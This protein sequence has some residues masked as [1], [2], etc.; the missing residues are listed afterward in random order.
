M[1]SILRT[2]S[3]L[4]TFIPFWLSP[5]WYHPKTFLNVDYVKCGGKSNQESKGEGC[6]SQKSCSSCRDRGKRVSSIDVPMGRHVSVIFALI[7][8]N[9]FY[10][11]GFIMLYACTDDTP[12]HMQQ[13]FLRKVLPYLCPWWE[14]LL[15]VWKEGLRAV[16]PLFPSSKYRA[17]RVH[18]SSSARFGGPHV[19]VTADQLV[20]IPLYRIIGVSAF[21]VKCK[22]DS[23]DKRQWI[24]FIRREVVPSVCCV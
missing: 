5:S 23:S 9:Y 15:P 11:N 1:D 10:P 21:L 19:K 16:V 17:Y 20:D 13:P 18:G 14:T 4:F 3:N 6:Q 8:I 2:G 24:P 12:T 22:L 7:V